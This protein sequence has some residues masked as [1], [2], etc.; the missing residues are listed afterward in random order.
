MINGVS[1]DQIA[2]LRL[3]NTIRHICVSS[4]PQSL[5][6]SPV[7]EYKRALCGPSPYLE[8]LGPLSSTF[9][10]ISTQV[11]IYFQPPTSY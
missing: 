9:N 8:T 11:M 6:T 10:P 1:L 4:V 3:K 5:P 7:T 2:I